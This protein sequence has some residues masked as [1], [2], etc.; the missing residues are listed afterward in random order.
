[1]SAQAQAIRNIAIIAHV[2]HG[3]TTLVDALLAQSGIFRDNEA[4]PTCVMDSN[5]L[6]RERG[7]TILSKNTAVTYNQ[8]RINIVDT[9]GHADFGGEVE[10]V[11]GMVDG[12]LLIV[13]ANEGPMPQTRFVLKKALEQG[14]RPI[15]FVNKIDRARVDPE[16]AVNKVLDL[17][18]ELG[19]DD[20]QCD[21]PYLF[22][23]G[24]GGFAKPDMATESDNMKPLFDAILRHVPPPVGDENKPLQ[25]QITT[26]DYSDFLGRIVIGR[27]HNGII[28]NGQSALLL[29]DDG[30]I[31]RGRISKLLGFE[32][33]QRVE[34]QQAGAG[35]LVALAGFDQV[36]IGETIACPDEPKALPLIKV[37]EPTLQMTFVVNDSPFAGKEGKFVTSRQLRDRLN[38]ELLTNVAL[39]VEDTDS[40]DRFAV[41]GR[42]ELHLG[43]LI[44][45]MRREGFEFQVSQPQVIFR[46]IDDIPCEPVETLVI[47]VPDVA[48][49]ACIE[50]LGVRRGEMQNMESGS[51]GR[52]QLEFVVP[53]RGLIGFRGEFVRATRGEGIMSHSFFEYR[54]MLG[55][56]DARRN[57][58]LIAFEQGTATFY[59]LKNAENRGQFFISP[60]AKVYKGMIVGENS[61]PQDLEL[62]VC[63]AKQLTNIRSAGAEEL[64]T[65][66]T[67]LQMTL[68]RALEYIA[69][70][71]MLE[72]TPESIRLRKLPTKKLA[73]R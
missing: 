34:I 45:T 3:K 61:R 65:L 23:S 64:D 43:I 22:G 30:S 17:F 47:D 57:G 33:L 55:E 2:D 60:G 56:F 39:R 72:V 51:D 73:K 63:K 12:C 19:A 44:E 29:K 35:D 20:D 18:I 28:R 13:D 4:V 25:L 70:D 66:Q 8:T 37:D 50:K 49:G 6:E 11:L 14:L 46:T 54:P 16:T 52:T 58:V 26:L 32:G 71:E 10:R 53:S 41:S 62:N 15:V 1:M 59:A 7:I 31:K 27:V 9:P 21:F 67:P 40:P 5:D 68:E 42:G 24:M 38:K 36:N 48:V 69:S